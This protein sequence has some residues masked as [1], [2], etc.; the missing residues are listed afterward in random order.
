MLYIALPLGVWV[1]LGTG[2][3]VA[4]VQAQGLGIVLALGSVAPTGS[5]PAFSLPSGIPVSVPHVSVEG[6]GVWLKSTMF[7]AGAVYATA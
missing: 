3:N 5:D 4:M 7:D 1:Q 2:L 6:G